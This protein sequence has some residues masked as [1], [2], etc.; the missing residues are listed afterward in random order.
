M[1]FSENSYSDAFLYEREVTNHLMNTFRETREIRYGI[2]LVCYAEVL[3]SPTYEGQAVVNGRKAYFAYGRHIYTKEMIALRGYAIACL[4]ELRE[5]PELSN[6]CD[7]VIANLRGAT[8]DDSAEQL[9]KAT[10]EEVYLGYV[11]DIETIDDSVLSGFAR[12]E[13]EL[14]VRNIIDADGLSFLGSSVETRIAA[15]IFADS[16]FRSEVSEKLQSTIKSASPTEL[17]SAISLVCSASVRSCQMIPH[18]ILGDIIES[19]I[20]VLSGSAEEI[21]ALGVLQSAVPNELL[22][23]WIELR[24][25]EQIRSLVLKHHTTETS[26]WLGRIDVA[27]FEKLGISSELAEDIEAGARAYGETVPY[28]IAMEI[29][30]ETPGFF[31]RYASGVLQSAERGSRAFRKLLPNDIN[32]SVQRAFVS[33]P[34]MLSLAEE[35]MLNLIDGRDA[36]WDTDFLGFVINADYTFPMKAVP[37]LMRFKAA[38]AMKHLGEAIWGKGSG[39]AFTDDVWEAILECETDMPEWERPRALKCILDYAIE[40]CSVEATSW[41]ASRSVQDGKLV[42][43]LPDVAM[44][45]SPNLRAEYIALL[46]RESHLD[47]EEL[48]KIP[49]FTSYLGSSWTE[50]EIPLLREKIDVLD[51]A[52]KYLSGI[53]FLKHRR[54]LEEMSVSVRKYLESVEVREFISEF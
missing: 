43:Y 51:E 54:V 26:E 18:L 20:D 13:R 42:D 29:D 23:R 25:V 4:A 24:G 30:A 5:Y 32:D 8:S 10:L 46:C 7:L 19:S 11:S 39:E 38:Y 44:E 31:A 21:I 47:S 52:M 50:S 41:L 9:W 27:R 1:C 12:L 36:Y 17:V 33:K 28:G 16:S 40:C 15:L 34:E 49:I 53:S 35:I 22:T 45:L 37:I 6:R 2:L 3:L 48:R 14:V